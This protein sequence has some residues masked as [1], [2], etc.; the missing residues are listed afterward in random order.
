MKKN[1]LVN[2]IF[3]E[4][5]NLPEV[6]YY[7]SFLQKKGI[8]CKHN[9]KKIDMDNIYSYYE[10]HILGTH[11]KHHNRFFCNITASKK[12]LIHEYASLSTG[13][14]FFISKVKNFIKKTFNHTP[15]YYLF[16]NNTIKDNISKKN[17]D[18]IKYEFRDMAVPEHWKKDNKTYDYDYDYD[19]AYVGS[20]SSERKITALLDNA[21]LKQKKILL[22]GEPPIELIERY[23]YNKNIFFE[24]KVKHDNVP[25]LLKKVKTCINYIPNEYP[26]NVQ[27]STKMLEYLFLEKDILSTK[28]NWVINFLIEKKIEFEYLD[29]DFI[30]IEGKNQSSKIPTWN[31][32]LENSKIIKKIINE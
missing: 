4:H 9:L 13:K 6:A 10:W 30:Y 19:Y 3:P 16:L 31:K 21:I 18:H 8:I 17:I 32:I 15:D 7:K 23:K 25:N 12:T 24:G 14:Y 2:F 22:I 11:L 27:T 20:L 1:I 29:D 28:Y 5:E 26:Y